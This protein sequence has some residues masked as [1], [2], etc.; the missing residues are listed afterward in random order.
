MNFTID[1]SAMPNQEEKPLIIGDYI[2]LMEDI[3][4][5]CLD[6]KEVGKT[7]SGEPYF[8]DIIRNLEKYSLLQIAKIE[9]DETILYSV[10]HNFFFDVGG[11]AFGLFPKEGDTGFGRYKAYKDVHFTASANAGHKR[12]VSNIINKLQCWQESNKEVIGGW[13][14][15]ILADNTKNVEKYKGGNTKLFGFFIGQTMKNHKSANP[16]I[17]NELLTEKLK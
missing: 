16:E 7:T 15:K 9:G 2:C 11:A 1:R 6:R 8:T 3:K 4:V 17:V 12:C 5:A 13:I 14:D 10:E